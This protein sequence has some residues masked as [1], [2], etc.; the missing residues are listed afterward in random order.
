MRFG[1]CL[2]MAASLP[3][4]TGAEYIEKLAQFGYDYAELPLAEMM[5]LSDRDF[6]TLRERVA[7]SGLKCEACNNFFPKTMRLTGS[8]VNMDEILAYVDKALGRASSMGAQIVVFGSGGA[9][10]VPDGFPMN[11]A[12]QQLVRLLRA[13]SPIAEKNGVT[14][15]L[16]PLRRQECNIVNT[17]REGCLLSKAAAC[18]NV[19]VLVDFYHLR[20]ENEPVEHILADGREY[21]RHTHFARPDGR[22]YPANIN[23][24]DYKPFI[25]ALKAV[26]YEG[27]VSCEAYSKDFE[28]DARA[29]LKFF[30]DNFY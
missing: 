1:C 30:R 17:F 24:Y 28:H 11:E 5:Q 19:K 23:E 10:N 14:V 16:E 22:I 3:D 21:L 25:G 29:A 13:I 6:E 15:T 12:H 7:K 18:K 26:G 4:G 2:N 20:E 9:K 8:A 27:R